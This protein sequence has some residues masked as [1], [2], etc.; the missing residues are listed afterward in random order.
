VAESIPDSR[1]VKTDD[2]I[3][4]SLHAVIPGGIHVGL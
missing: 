3:Q 2:A 1:P 4:V